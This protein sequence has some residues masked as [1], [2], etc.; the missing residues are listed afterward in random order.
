MYYS[1]IF[2]T[3]YNRE[4]HFRNC[5]ESL[6]ACKLSN[7]SHLFVAIDAPFRDEDIE[8]NK[9]IIQYSKNI[10]GFKEITLFIRPENYGAN[11]NRILARNEIFSKYDRLIMFED[12]NIFSTNFLY[13]LNK[14]LDIYNIREDIFSVSGYQ[15]PFIMPKNYKQDIYIWQGFSAWGVGIWREKWNHMKYSSEKIEYWLN[16]KEHLKK[17]DKVSQHYRY[18][19]N[20]MHKKNRISEDGFISSYLIENNMYSVFPTQTLVKNIGH[21][22][23]G[24]NK[25]ISK[26]FL[27]QE[28]YNGPIG[29]LPYDIQPNEKINK[30]LW[31]YFSNLNRLK[32]RGEHL[33]NKLFMS[34]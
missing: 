32:N 23:K 24:N 8:V 26:K 17:L 4:K 27:K 19:L 29:D 31:W 18:A 10:S 16:N 14:A 9:R 21:D 1:P 13:Y 5:I 33:L 15:Y 30:R 25:F 34:K 2:V 12:D 11:K 20:T 7:N 3:V 28:I 22:G 6:K